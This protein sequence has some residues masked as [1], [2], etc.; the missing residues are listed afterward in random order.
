MRFYANPTGYGAVGGDSY[1][2]LSPLVL[3]VEL[4]YGVES[5][6]WHL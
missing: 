3:V 6:E 2:G 4:Y 1:C 5:E